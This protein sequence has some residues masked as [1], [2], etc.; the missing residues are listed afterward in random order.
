[1]AE[2]NFKELSPCGALIM[3]IVWEAPGEISVQEL[4]DQLNEKYQKAYART[5]VVTFL[6]KLK[7]KGYIDT[8]RKGKPAYIVV[9]I[10]EDEYRREILKSNVEFWYNGNTVDMIATICESQDLGKDGIA[11]YDSLITYNDEYFV[12]RDFYSYIEAQKSLQELY[13]NK[14][15]W[16]KISL[17]NTAC[18]GFFSS[19]RTIE[20]YIHDIWFKE[21]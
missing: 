3:N 6:S 20:E 1:M 17:K 2:N 14:D 4:I 15:L 7:D 10:T 18:S 11:I 13:I 5:T 21:V 19:D 8:Y 16:N 9:R 12:L